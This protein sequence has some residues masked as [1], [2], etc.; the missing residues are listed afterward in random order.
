MFLLYSYEYSRVFLIFISR[1][2]N[3]FAN[4][5]PKRENAKKAEQQNIVGNLP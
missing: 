5:M 4:P 1:L 3:C 2:F